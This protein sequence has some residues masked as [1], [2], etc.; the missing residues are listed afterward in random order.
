MTTESAV[1]GGGCFWCTE[2]I[3]KELKGVV[4]VAPGYAGGEMP[5]PTY[6]QVCGGDTGHAEVIR[7]EFDPA[8]ISFSDILQVFFATHDPTTLNRQGN[9]VGTQYRSI[10]L[11]ADAKQKSE[12]ETVIA[13]LKASGGYGGR[14]VVTELKP[15]E[16]FWEAEAYHRDY[17]AKNRGENPYCQLVIDPKLKKFREKFRSLLKPQA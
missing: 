10:I 2:S 14:E 13:E 4:S 16:K 3:F 8:A 12:A 9:D 7:V 1:L 5:E 17:Y 15:L 6:E 11:Y